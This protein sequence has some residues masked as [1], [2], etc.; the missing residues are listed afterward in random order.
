[1]GIRLIVDG[2]PQYCS[3][4]ELIVLFTPFG[5]VLSAQLPRDHLLNLLGFGFVEMESADNA[6]RAMF[7]LNGH[8][9]HGHTI[10]V[11]LVQDPTSAP[12]S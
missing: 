8:E 6:S 5:S 10:T 3:E 1:M 9:L 12:A 7:A 2:L 11:G 4:E